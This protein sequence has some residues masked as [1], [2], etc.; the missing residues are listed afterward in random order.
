MIALANGHYLHNIWVLYA[1]LYMVITLLKILIQING[2]GGKNYGWNVELYAAN[3][4]YF[5]VTLAATEPNHP[6]IWGG[7]LNW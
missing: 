1:V 7:V 3:K 4:G 6:Q 2:R 5:K